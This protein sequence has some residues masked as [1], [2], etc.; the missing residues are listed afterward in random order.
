MAEPRELLSLLIERRD[1]SQHQA[2]ALLE[3]LT[4]GDTPAALAGALLAARALLATAPLDRLAPAPAD[5]K[6]PPGAV[7]RTGSLA[8]ARGG[9]VIVGFQSALPH[10]YRNPGPDETEVIWAI[11]PPSY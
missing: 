8:I 2:E 10:R 3:V 7:A 9:P 6:D 11:T 4:A 1:L 5:P